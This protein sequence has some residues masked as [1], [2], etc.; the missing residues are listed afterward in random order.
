MTETVECLVLKGIKGIAEGEIFYIN[1]GQIVTIGRSR[2]CDISFHR[3]K[4][5]NRLL[6]SKKDDDLLSVSR[7][8]L[9]IAFYNSQCV[10]LK[11][12]S[13]NGSFINKRSFKKK[14][15]PDI[16][17]KTYEI[18][19]GARETF[20]LS[21]NKRELDQPEAIKNQSEKQTSAGGEE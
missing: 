9:R 15:I 16:K 10:E 18:R 6:K 19:L 20:E 14:I 5:F 3:F 1:Y 11:D 2:S 8:H 7:R 17:G 13:T 4:K 12:L 21:W